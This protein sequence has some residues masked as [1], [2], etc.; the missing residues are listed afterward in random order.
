MRI[1]YII[2]LSVLTCTSLHAQ[3]F[4]F[5]KENYSD[6]TKL[7]NTLPE[8]ARQIQ[9]SLANSNE[10]LPLFYK[11]GLSLLVGDYE[12]AIT[13]VDSMRQDFDYDYKNGIYFPFEF[14]ARA[15]KEESINTPFQSTLK[16]QF[17]E[18]NSA[19]NVASQ[20]IV[21]ANAAYPVEYL[22]ASLDA[23]L[24][25]QKV[26]DTLQ[27]SNAL[28]L[29]TSYSW[30]RVFN[31]TSSVMRQEVDAYIQKIFDVKT[32]EVETQ[33]GSKLNAH[34]VH[35]KGLTEGLPT[36][37]IYNIYADS[38]PDITTAKYY[39]AEGYAAIVVNTRGKV[40]NENDLAPFEY[41]AKDA[42]D[43]IDWISKQKWS[44]GEVAMVGGS[45][46]GFAQWASVKRL[47]PALRTI[48]P[49][50]AVGPGID[51][52]M[53]GNVFMSYMLRWI[54]YVTNNSTT[55]IADFSNT[56][57]WNS[58]YKKWYEE[59]SSFRSLDSLEGKSS[60]IFH[61]WL[62][63]PSFD[64]YWQNMIPHK[65]EFSKIDIP[66]LTTTGYFDDDQM[67]ALY[68]YKQHHQYNPKANH[69]LVIGP[70]THYGAQRYP[71]IEVSGYEV[72]PIATSINFRKLSVE[73]FDYVLSNGEKP[74][75]LKDKVNFQIMGTNEWGH[76]PTLSGMSNDTLTFY[77]DSTEIDNHYSMSKTA[78][79]DYLEQEVDLADRSDARDFEYKVIRDSI[80]ADL[81]SSLSFITE[82]FEE[83]VIFSGSFIS[84]LKVAINKKDF[85]IVI[86]AYEL[87][88]DGRYFSLFTES[89]FSVLQRASYAKDNTQRQLLT[90]NKKETIEINNSYITAKQMGKGSR[91][92]IALGVNKS[93]YW[94]VNY[95]T[96]K[97]VSDETI[98]DAIEPLLIK[99]FGDSFIKV[100]ILK[101]ND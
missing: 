91:L 29:V 100:P 98:A 40:I 99:W 90:P 9:D 39:A 50:V 76:A 56:N 44:N 83:A 72:D 4:F 10:P 46:L 20:E 13:Y 15:K 48:M 84:N 17:Q 80:T 78:G 32:I 18:I 22:K 54:R 7:A 89:G 70:Y 53:T 62:D 6:S 34:I 16:Q 94:Q 68:Y 45:Y 8:L 33:N 57:K 24:E 2:A 69:Y 79:D 27:L 59:G 23:V 5:P 26:S 74:D 77:F 30:Y 11:L 71:D 52:P 87:M 21:E 58:L 95:G 73:W 49:Q 25:Q 1:I 51:Y 81:S 63:H 14:Y 35:K 37:F 97:D 86:S 67:G 64:S 3:E 66:I 47:H 55:D 61:R 65:R 12:A 31:Q 88:P 92:V 82:P 36:V 96:G 60:D 28:Q 42:Y 85:D 41:D 38:L 43:I 101:T 19:L 93:P 75:F